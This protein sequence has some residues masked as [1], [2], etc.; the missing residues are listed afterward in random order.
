MSGGDGVR[1]ALN[2]NPRVQIA[3]FAGAVIALVVLFMTS[4][5]SGPEPTPDPAAAP[6]AGAP[7]PGAAAAEATP[8][9]AATDPVPEAA[10]DPVPAPAPAPG[11]SAGSD[12]L[13]PTKGLPKDLLVA[14]AK[15]KAIALLVVDPD[16][17]SDRALESYTRPI[18]SRD[19][20]ELFVASVGEVARYSRITQGVAVNKAPALV[21]IRPRDKTEAAPTASVSYG[22]R[23]SKSIKIALEDALY[24]GKPVTSY[25]G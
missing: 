4:M 10:V 2:E 15:N 6:A 17:L 20:V 3:F 18:A 1:K 25:P 14:Y 23:S 5:S 7:A 11:V 16:G 19:D 22:F 21:V 13:L 8:G 24:K 12:G 9:E